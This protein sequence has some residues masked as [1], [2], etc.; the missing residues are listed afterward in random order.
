MKV[1]ILI[2]AL[3]KYY[4]YIYLYLSLLITC[5]ISKKGRRMHDSGIHT[6]ENFE[7]KMLVNRDV[8]ATGPKFS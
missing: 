7:P 2:S 5:E 1:A 8:I 6:T 3:Y 4:C